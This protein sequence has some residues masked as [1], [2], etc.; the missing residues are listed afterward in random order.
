MGKAIAIM[1]IKSDNAHPPY[2]PKN[3]YSVE[4]SGNAKLWPYPKVG[5]V[6]RNVNFVN[7]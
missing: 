3:E 6:N 7:R 4:N 5:T 1:L 2:C